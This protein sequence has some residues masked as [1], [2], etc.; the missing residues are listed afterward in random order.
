MRLLR[1]TA[2]GAGALTMLAFAVEGGEYGTTDVLSQKGRRER[3]RAEVASL[4]A[5]VESLR[6]ELKL[7]STDNVRLERIAREQ[8]GMVK[9]DKEVIYWTRRTSDSAVVR[10]TSRSPAK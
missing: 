2:W 4:R 8:F 7:V 5:D 10:D 3:L 9:G 1:R 6:V